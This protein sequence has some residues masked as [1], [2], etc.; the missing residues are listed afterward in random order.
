MTPPHYRL[1]DHTADFGLEIFGQDEKTLFSNAAAAL[2]AL[3]VD[4]THLE[5]Q[6]K[7]VL[8]V[9]GEDWPDLL[10]NWLRELL[11]LWNGEE[12]LVQHVDI[13]E[14]EKHRLHASVWTDDYRPDRHTIKN[15]IKAVTY[16]QI[17]VTST[18]TGWQ[19]RVIF[20]V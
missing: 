9:T 11:Y 8:E 5:G 4:A 13:D 10:V 3:I 17:D 15:E 12:Q 16:H 19:A 2:Y 6:H 14:I 1:I 20:D 7:R 18:Q